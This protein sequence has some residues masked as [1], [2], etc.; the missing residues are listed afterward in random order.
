MTSFFIFSDN[1]LQPSSTL[2]A[3]NN[4]NNILNMESAKK[5]IPVGSTWSNAGS[6]N[7][8]LDNLLTKKSGKGQAPSMN[9]LKS[10]NSSP[11]KLATPQ[12]GG[13]ISPIGSNISN[14]KFN[15]SNNNSF[16]QFNAFQ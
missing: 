6:I 10:A 4:G 16:N 15:Q 8:D 1:I 5:S 3:M 12:S 14:F 13:L 9:Q 2:I 7:I 11:V